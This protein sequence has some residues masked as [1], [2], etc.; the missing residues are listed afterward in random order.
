MQL[1]EAKQRFI[2]TWGQMSSHWGINRNM[3]H[4]HA[5]L[6][7]SSEPICA[8]CIADDLKISR[9]ST[10]E[11]LRNL[12]DWELVKKKVILGER[13]D[14]Y[15]AEKDIWLV[16]RRILKNRKRRELDPLFE[17]LQ[18]LRS[19]PCDCQEAEE[20]RKM[21]GDVGDLSKKAGHFLDKISNAKHPSTS[22][23]LLNLIG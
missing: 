11:N 14:H 19:V 4:I 20:F 16:F 2:E 3:A 7:V 8:E 18:E 21:V 10:C 9:G 15:E 22:S 13:K 5:L 17:V 6:L 12:L 1:D 23:I